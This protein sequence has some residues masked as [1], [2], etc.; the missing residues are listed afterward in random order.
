MGIDFAGP[1]FA[2]TSSSSESGNEKCYVCL[3][4][5]ASTRAVHLE[6]TRNLTVYSFLLAFRRFT[7]RKGLPATLITDNAKTFRGGSKEI[8]KILRSKE[9]MRYVTNRRIQWKFIVEKAPW[10]GGFWERLIQNVKRCLTKAIGRTILSFD[11]LNTLL[12]E[13]EGVVNSRPLTYV[14]DD[15]DGISYTLS[16]PHL[17]NGRRIINSPNAGHFEVVSTNE[18]L[19]RR[20]KQHRHLVQQFTN[21]W[22]NDYLLS[23]REKHA[24][25][26]HRRGSEIAVGDVVILKND[27]T[28]RVFWKL[29]VVEKLLPGKDGHVRAAHVKVASADR[30]PRIFTR[31]VKHLF[32]LE[33]NTTN[34][35]AQNEGPEH[36]AC[37]PSASTESTLRPRRSTAVV[38][39][40]IRRLR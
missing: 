6:L 3:F 17:I 38:G 22:R 5:C 27:S 36:N 26:S 11:E 10:W 34:E 37:F 24:Q 21:K 25:G 12:L 33:V 16:P 32:P 40:M 23:L 19:S 2:Q 8:V 30:N 9:V 31:S 35:I 28:Q 1:L 15:Q 7:S 39:E 18:S 20:I 14:E 4:T 29:A 13:V